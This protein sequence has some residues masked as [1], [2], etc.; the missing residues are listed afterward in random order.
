MSHAISCHINSTYS[1]KERYNWDKK[2]KC[3]TTRRNFQAV[4]QTSGRYPWVKASSAPPNTPLR[5]YEF[6][7]LTEWL[8]LLESR[9][10]QF[11]FRFRPDHYTDAH[12]VHFTINLSENA[13]ENRMGDLV[14]GLDFS[15]Y[16]NTTDPICIKSKKRLLVTSAPPGC[17]S[18]CPPVI[19][20]AGSGARIRIHR[21]TPVVFLLFL[22]NVTI[23]PASLHCR[24]CIQFPSCVTNK[25]R[26][27]SCLFN[28]ICPHLNHSSVLA[29]CFWIH[30]S[31]KD[32]SSFKGYS[33]PFGL[34]TRIPENK[35]FFFPF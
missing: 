10:S 26:A 12:F 6:W 16:R 17:T 15:L 31:W 30:P 34:M 8:R 22:A 9:R 3:I 4:S 21:D 24:L 28:S 7:N 14:W 23:G 29:F 19:H 18:V 25:W 1:L 35:D 2:A 5:V 33:Q 27:A 20:S 11:L 13:E 32:L